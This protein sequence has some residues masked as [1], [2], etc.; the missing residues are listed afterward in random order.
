MSGLLAAYDIGESEPQDCVQILLNALASWMHLV[1]FSSV[2][3]KQFKRQ[4]W[5]HLIMVIA[6]VANVLANSQQ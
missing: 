1:Q 2:L 4:I 6:L 3:E 5:A